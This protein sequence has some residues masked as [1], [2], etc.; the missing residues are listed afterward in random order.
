MKGLSAIT[1]LTGKDL[2]EMGKKAEETSTRTLQSA[3]DIVKAYQLM[4][5]K[6]PELLANGDALAY[7]T[8]QA[9]IL[10]ES[11][12]GLLSLEDATNA[13]AAALNAFNLEGSQAG[14]VIN[15]LAA[16]SQAGSAEVQDLAASLKNVGSVAS[17]SNMSLS[18]TVAALETL[19]ENQLYA[20]EAGTKLRGTILKLKDAGMGYTSGQFDFNDALEEA[21]DKIKAIEESADYK[22][23]QAEEER[24]RKT[25]A[26]R[27]AKEKIANGIKKSDDL[28]AAQIEYESDKKILDKKFEFEIFFLKKNR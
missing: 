15:I 6:R 11:S 4:G 5:S 24:R 16:G 23:Q 27:L 9:I 13:T 14:E 10:S 2:E 18:E 7:V 8:E 25:E 3:T 12:G 28:R 1:G 26:L 22:K 19:G 21:R 20:E 17:T